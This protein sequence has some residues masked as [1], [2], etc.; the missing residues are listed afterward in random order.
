LNLQFHGSDLLLAILDDH[1]INFVNTFD[2]NTGNGLVWP[3]YTSES[4]YMYT[5]PPEGTVPIITSDIYRD[6]AMAYLANLALDHPL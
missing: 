6:Q 3:E 4:K 1:V 5:F 2:P